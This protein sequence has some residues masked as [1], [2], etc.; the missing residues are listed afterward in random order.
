[1]ATHSPPTPAKS[2]LPMSLAGRA[3]LAFALL[4][5]ATVPLV[6]AVEPQLAGAVMKQLADAGEAPF[7]IQ[8]A[9]VPIDLREMFGE[10]RVAR[11]EVLPRGLDHRCVETESGGYFEGKAPSW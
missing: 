3:W 2:W 10:L 11:A 6:L 5:L 8:I 7:V 1:M 4:L 9:H